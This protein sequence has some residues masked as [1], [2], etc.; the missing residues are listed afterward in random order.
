MRAGLGQQG[1]SEHEDLGCA[2][3]STVPARE[4]LTEP[5]H[6]VPKAVHHEAFGRHRRWCPFSGRGVCAGERPNEN[7]EA[8]VQAA[9]Q[10]QEDAAVFRPAKG[11]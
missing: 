2:R 5:S 9:A 1:S 11:S 10:A 8:A 3:A 4:H 6:R 7:L